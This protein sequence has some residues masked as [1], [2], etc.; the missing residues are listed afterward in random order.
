[1]GAVLTAKLAANA[2]PPMPL[3]SSTLTLL[4][5]ALATIRSGL[6]SA[7]KSPAA[8]ALG[9]VAT[10]KLTATA[11]LAGRWPIRSKRPPSSMSTE[12]VLAELQ[13]NNKSR[14]GAD[15]RWTSRALL[16]HV[17]R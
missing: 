8:T 11:K 17:L 4:V 3:L 14:Q 13:L 2:K 9:L 16:N 1:M 12:L 5:P 15:S 6:P 10:G 7:L